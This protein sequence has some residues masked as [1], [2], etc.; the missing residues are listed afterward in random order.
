[1]AMAAYPLHK[2]VG[3]TGTAQSVK[4]ENAG[5]AQSPTPGKPHFR[6]MICTGQMQQW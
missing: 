6:M 2:K 3:H 1:M 5:R 4:G